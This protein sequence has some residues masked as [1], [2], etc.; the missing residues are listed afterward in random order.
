[1]SDELDEFCDFAVKMDA[2]DA[3]LIETKNIV[4]KNSTRWSCRFGCENYGK[5]LMCPPY[6]PTPDETRALLKEYKWALLVR[7]KVAFD[8]REK[9][10]DDLHKL[11]L[12]LEHYAFIKGFYSALGFKAGRCK[13]CE[14][15][16]IEGGICVNPK[17]A[18]PSM[19]SLG[20]DVFSTAKKAGYEV[21]VLTSKDQEYYIYGLLLVK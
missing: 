17:S 3:K 4:V 1:M 14:N 21:E 8:I 7:K 10:A 6:S 18:R 11:M 13:L 16:N 15:C 20:I 9:S 12:D 19:E 2:D 5:S